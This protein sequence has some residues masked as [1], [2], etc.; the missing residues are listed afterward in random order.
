MLLLNRSPK[1]KCTE[2]VFATEGA[3]KGQYYSREKA[4]RNLIFINP[5]LAKDF[6]DSSEHNHGVYR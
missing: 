1:G 3:V 6:P 5:D 4:D 2:K